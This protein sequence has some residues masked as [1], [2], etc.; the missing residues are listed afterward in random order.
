[1][2]GKSKKEHQSAKEIMIAEANVISK[3]TY[4]HTYIYIC[5]ETMLAK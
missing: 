1:M 2:F 4:I 3:H 5:T